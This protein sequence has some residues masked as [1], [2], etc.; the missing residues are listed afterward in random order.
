MVAAAL[1]TKCRVFTALNQFQ[2]H[3]FDARPTDRQKTGLRRT[4]INVRHPLR[5]GCV[6]GMQ[7]FFA[8]I[9]KTLGQC[10]LKILPRKR[11]NPRTNGE[12]NP[13]RLLITE[14]GCH[15]R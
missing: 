5:Q 1:N 6:E 4:G 2:Q 3:V 10:G 14:T 9:E 15:S 13:D 7:T 11:Q 8:I 12:T